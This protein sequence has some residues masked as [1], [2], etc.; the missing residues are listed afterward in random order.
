M[1]KNIQARFR[2]TSIQPLNK[3][4]MVDKMGPS[5]LFQHSHEA[6]EE[7][8][9]DDVADEA[10]EVENHILIEEVL[11]EGLPSPPRQYTQY[12]VSLEDDSSSLCPNSTI[13]DP[14]SAQPISQFLRLIEIRG[15]RSS[16]IRSELLVDYNH[17]QILI[18]N[19]HVEKLITILTKNAMIEEERATKQKERELSKAGGLKRGCSK[20]LPR[21]RG[22]V[23]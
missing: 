19:D 21:G 23:T 1:M 2:A 20:Q 14:N 13:A 12:F 22:L 17:S 10:T 11:E 7:S 9:D 16:R 8:K 6:R 4:A 18:S 15:T 3:E 5:E